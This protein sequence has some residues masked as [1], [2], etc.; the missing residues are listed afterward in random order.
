MEYL[1]IEES[2]KKLKVSYLTVYK[3]VHENKIPAIRVGRQWR[4]PADAV[5]RGTGSNELWKENERDAK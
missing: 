4:I 2:A 5:E 1:T 3:L